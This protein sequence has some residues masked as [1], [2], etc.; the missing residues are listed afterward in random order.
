MGCQVVTSIAAAREALQREAK[1]PN[2]Q[3]SLKSLA[4][5]AM[6]DSLSIFVRP[7]QGIP[8]GDT[9]TLYYNTTVSPLP[10]GARPRLKAG[11][12]KWQ[13]IQVGA[14]CTQYVLAPSKVNAQSFTIILKIGGTYRWVG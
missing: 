5:A 14:R 7:P 6:R 10:F 1:S 12:N 4:Q 9:G 13:D 11:I 8:S 3:E 2:K